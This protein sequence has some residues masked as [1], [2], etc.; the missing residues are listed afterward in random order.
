MA[1]EIRNLIKKL[2]GTFDTDVIEY[3]IGEVT[4][5]NYPEGSTS[6]YDSPEFYNTC[7]VKV[8]T[9]RSIESDSIIYDAN[10]T[11]EEQGVLNSL[12]PGLVLNNVSLAVDGTSITNLSIPAVGSKVVVFMSKYQKPFIT[13]YSNIDYKKDIFADG[14]A[15]SFSGKD[16]RNLAGFAWEILSKRDSAH[17]MQFL[18]QAT[19]NT[20]SIYQLTSELVNINTPDDS[21]KIRIQDDLVGLGY[22]NNGVQIQ[23]NDATLY[24]ANSHVTCFTTGKVEIANTVDTLGNLL[25]DIT[26]LFSISAAPSGG[27]GGPLVAGSAVV[28]SNG[29]TTVPLTPIS[30]YLA[31]VLTR[32]SALL[33]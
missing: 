22:N 23:S 32:L 26:I 25:G 16:T 19:D 24:T 1:N 18:P 30:T 17:I 9:S 3:A 21:K 8:L 29:V 15:V 2:A 33:Q 28:L 4:E 20:K 6:I 27:S 10:T 11:I 7:K 14:D 13:Q 31:N 12:Y 5:I